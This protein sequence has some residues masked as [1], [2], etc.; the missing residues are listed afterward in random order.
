MRSSAPLILFV[1]VLGSVSV[2]QA[3]EPDT[4]GYPEEK[5][6]E[7]HPRLVKPEGEEPDNAQLGGEPSLTEVPADPGASVDGEAADDD[8]DLDCL[9]AQY[10]EEEDK[11]QRRKRTLE[12]AR[13]S[14][15]ISEES[16]ED[17]GDA[18]SAEPST[19]SLAEAET[20]TPDEDRALPLRLGPVRI[21]VGKSD[22]WIGIGFAAQM[23]FEYDQQLEGAGFLRES[24]E[25]LEFRRIR[26]TLS[27]SF[28]EGRIRSRF[29]I[30]LTPSAFELIDLWFSFTRFKFA[31]FRLGQFK[32]PYDRYRA[33]SFAVLSFTDWAPTTT[34]F[35]SERQIG[36][37]MLATGGFLD[38]EYA[39]GI[40]SGVNA[41]AAHGVGIT[42]VYGEEPQNASDFGGGEVVSSFHPE[43]AMRVAKN[44]GKIN[45]DTNSDVTGSSELRHS[46]GTGIAWDARPE[47][48]DD[49]GLR[50]SAEW[51][52][53]IRH[54]HL[55]LIAYLA[56]FKPWEGGK[57]L[58]G[59]MGFMGEAGYRF[60]TLWELA[61]RYS[62]TYLTPWL[63][64]DSRSYGAVQISTAA[65]PALALQKYGRNGDQTTNNE[66]A[67]AGTSHIIGNSLKVVG[68][69]AWM[70]QRWDTGRRN[71][72]R[73]NLQFQLLF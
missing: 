58:F 34:M 44:F 61:L 10:E 67:V 24:Q 8:C 20:E 63:R 21:R 38:L 12:V 29:Q 46:L 6:E 5:P 22:D 16:G 4:A 40:F 14:G 2:G 60:S 33:Q 72:I 51:L 30:N 37:E 57:I 50:L 49:L 70:A 35:G 28:I 45:T 68:E 41:R 73:L 36:A 62:M 59:P 56:W 17:S 71:G 55:N 32:I 31:T 42:L 15:S 3:E 9:E 65:D 66:L 1:M 11:A 19:T 39:I 18:L 69:M 23:E 27:S 64:S 54:F 25:R 53:K 48:I 43:L 47:A 52:A 13:E 26:S 7:K